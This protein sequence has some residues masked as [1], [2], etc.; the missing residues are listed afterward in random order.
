MKGFTLIEIIIVTGIILI[1]FSITFASY[2]TGQKNFAL[3]RSDN[4]LARDLRATQEMA[5]SSKEVAGTV[6]D[7]FGIHF[8]VSSSDYYILFAD[9]DGNY[10]RKSDGTE[11]LEIINLEQ[12]I[13]IS[14]LLPVSVFSI[15]FFP[16]DPTVWING[17]SSG[18]IGRIT[19]SAQGGLSDQVVL[20]NN[21]GLIYVE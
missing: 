11:D 1:L 17:L 20:V 9:F 10:S 3:Q 8:D 18:V 5:M 7:G 6:P 12:G 16:P 21:A 19:L 13:I 2:G 14:G 15:V 4:K